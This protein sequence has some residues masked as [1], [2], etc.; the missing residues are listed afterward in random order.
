VNLWAAAMD[1]KLREFGI[2]LRSSACLQ[3]SMLTRINM[4]TRYRFDEWYLNS[5][6]PSAHNGE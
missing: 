1:L 3:V 6:L 5:R 4:S 2:S